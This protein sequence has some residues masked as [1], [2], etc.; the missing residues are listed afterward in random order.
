MIN[1]HPLVPEPQNMVTKEYSLKNHT[2]QICDLSTDEIAKS[3]NWIGSN[4]VTIKILIF[5]LFNKYNSNIY[6]MVCLEFVI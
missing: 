5:T 3:N 1:S 2:V 6:I 4:Q